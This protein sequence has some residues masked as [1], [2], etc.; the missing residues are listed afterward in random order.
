[1][2]EILLSLPYFQTL[3]WSIIC[4]PLGP[5]VA[6]GP[7]EVACHAC[8]QAAPLCHTQPFAGQPGLKGQKGIM[9]RYGKMGPSGMKGQCNIQ[10]CF[11]MCGSL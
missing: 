6:W 2:Y 4:Q 11:F 8:S 10:R 1:M 9:G 3:L 7:R 5:L